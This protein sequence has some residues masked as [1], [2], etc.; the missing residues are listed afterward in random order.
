M[1]RQVTWKISLFL[2]ALVAASIVMGALV[3]RRWARAELVRRDNPETWNES[4]MRTFDHTVKPTPEQRAKIQSL[5]DGAVVELKT[6]RAETI[7]R[8]TNVIWR[9]VDQ[10]ERELTPEQKQAF[11]AM[12]PK[13]NDLGSLDVLQVESGGNPR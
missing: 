12:K 9:L 6:I 2:L 11:E 1:N 10:V 3:G 4:A 5:L 13:Q 7:A 8:S